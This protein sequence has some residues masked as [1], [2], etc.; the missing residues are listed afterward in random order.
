MRIVLYFINWNDSFY[1]P[2]LKEHYGKF[3]ERIVMYDHYST[4]GSTEI[5]RSLGFEIRNFGQRNQ[6]N[7]QHYLDVKNNCWKECRG[8]GIDYVIVC[9]ADEFV[10]IDDN[11][12]GSAPVVTGY[13]MIS[14]L[15]PSKSIFEIKT[16]EYSE[17]Y[18]KQAIFNPDLINEI[19]YVHGCHKN[20]ITGN[21]STEGSATLYHFRQIGGVER[22]I[23][24]HAE[25]R[26][27]MSAFNKQHNMA[28][29]Y[30][31]SDEAKIQEWNHLKSNAKE[32]W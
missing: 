14:E 24:R 10:C 13:N 19:S 5:A 20:N 3:C 22:M 16:G 2:F 32:L 27:R 28:W 12:K 26:N 31:H 18:S 30:N 9:D 1:L 25:Y 23:K 21:I 17:G 4:D 6:L 29:H 15:L 7:D 11:L 8:K